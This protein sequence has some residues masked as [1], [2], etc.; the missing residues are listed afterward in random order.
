MNAQTE[1]KKRVEN[2]KTH[3]FKRSIA[4][5]S[6]ILTIFGYLVLGFWI[7][8]NDDS[9]MSML[10]FITGVTIVVVAL[11]LYLLSPSRYLRE[12]IGDALSV[13]SLISLNRVLSALLIEARGVYVESGTKG[14]VTVFLPLSDKDSVSVA[15]IV[16]ESWVLNVSGPIKGVTLQPPGFGLYAYAQ[17]IGAVFTPESLDSGI[18]DVMENGLELASKVSTKHDANSYTVSMIGLVNHGMCDMV[19]REDPAICL[20]MGCPVCSS[21]ACMIADGTG[22]KVRVANVKVTGKNVDVTY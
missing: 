9:T 15:N 17:K 6:T 22:R 4:W 18:K 21:V 11:L 20:R 12:E 2:N 5:T 1:K 14:V 19:R 3:S 16:P 8:T 7:F 10:L 13:S